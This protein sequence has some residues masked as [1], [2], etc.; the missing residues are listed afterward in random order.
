MISIFDLT[1]AE[2]LELIHQKDIEQ[3]A[4]LAQEMQVVDFADFLEDVGIVET[5]YVF[6]VIPQD[7]MALMFSYLSIEK[8]KLMIQAFSGEQIQMLLAH[9]QFDDVV[10]FLNEMPSDIVLR[11]LKHATSEQR[12]ELDILLSYH[13][14][15][16]GAL[17]TTEYLEILEDDTV[18]SALAKVR[19]QGQSAASI[20]TCFVVNHNNRLL[21]TVPLKE[22]MISEKD[23]LIADLMETDIISVNTK[24]DQETVVQVFVRYDLATIPVVNDQYHLVGIIT[25]DDA[26]DVIR[27]EATEDI[28]RMASVVPV[29]GSYLNTSV[30]EMFKSRIPWL[31]ILMVSASFT[32]H[33]ISKNETLL[34]LLPSLYSFIPML[35]DTAGN[36]GSQASAMV[37]RGIVVDDLNIKDYYKVLLKE[38]QSSLL[39]GFILFAINTLRIIIF[40]P[41]VSPGVAIVVSLTVYLT[42]I[43]ANLVGGSLPLIAL[44]FKVDPASMSGPV[45]TTVVDGIALIV[46]FWIASGFIGM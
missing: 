19:D 35:M 34:L 45:V 22:V 42:V 25:A 32:G 2:F 44:I 24:D 36:A 31:L 33:I 10:D 16:A 8:Q 37:I 7:R 29:E 21:G 40:M 43:L 27:E 26:L 20:N 13:P 30:F 23:V 1:Q 41:S 5:M 28:L 9:S 38:M 18:A 46:Y 15:T 3:L 4:Y 11:V 12:H 6:Q 17:L 14:D 39:T